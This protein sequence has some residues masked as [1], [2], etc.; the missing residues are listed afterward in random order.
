MHIARGGGCLGASWV[1]GTNWLVGLRDIGKKWN[2]HWCSMTLGTPRFCAQR[3]SHIAQHVGWREGGG[4]APSM[5]CFCSGMCILSW[6]DGVSRGEWVF[7]SHVSFIAWLWS[8]WEGMVPPH[9]LARHG[10]FGRAC[11]NYCLR[12]VGAPRPLAL[13]CE[14]LPPLK[15]NR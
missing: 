10:S 12:F 9:P 4:S 1:R 3:S 13:F 15:L 7:V 5:S 2:R 6:A 11:N 8:E 14:Y